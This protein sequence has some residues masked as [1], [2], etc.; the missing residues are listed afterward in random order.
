VLS[1]SNKTGNFVLGT[2]TVD[3]GGRLLSDYGT[4]ALQQTSTS[5]TL[6]FTPTAPVS[7]AAEWR[8]EHFGVDWASLPEADDSADPDGDGVSNLL[9]RAFA[10]DP[11]VPEP[12]LLPSADAT[13]PALSF[14]YRRSKDA[15]DLD[16]TVEESVNLSTWNAAAGTETVIEDNA[17]YQLIRHTRPISSDVRLFLRVK[18]TQP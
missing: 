8:V 2:V 12:A 5:V 6:A 13:S 17:D 16:F 14:L 7:P 15:T 4:L 1:A 10:G 9:E 11:L 3:S 18:V